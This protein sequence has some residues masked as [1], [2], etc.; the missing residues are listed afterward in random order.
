MTKVVVEILDGDDGKHILG[1]GSGEWG[2]GSG[3]WEFGVRSLELGVWS[4]SN[5]V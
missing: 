3:E 5:S 4:Y 2:V 1:V